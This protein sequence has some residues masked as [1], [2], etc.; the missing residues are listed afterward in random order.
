MPKKILVTGGAGYIG[1]HTCVELSQSGYELVIY[2]NLSNSSFE[3]VKRVEKITNKS[4]KF[5]QG[6]ILD[7]LLLKQTFLEHDFYGVMHFAGLKAVGESVQ[8]PLLYYK[9]NVT[10]TLNLLDV[11]KQYDVKNLV[12]SSSATVYGDPEKLPILENSKRSCTNPYG[13]TKLTIEYVLEDLAKS[14][15][16]QDNGWNIISLRYFNPIGAHESGLIGEDPN[17]IPNNLMPYISQVA[18]GKLERLSVFGNDY[19]TVD[20]TGVRDYIHVVDLAKGHV[21]AIEYISQQAQPVGFTPINLGTGC[22]TSVLQLVNAFVE[23]TG[24]SIPYVVTS[25]RDGDI[26]SCYASVDKAKKLLNWQANL[27]IGDMCRDTWQWQ[28]KNPLGYK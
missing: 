14:E 2:D 25:R 7:Q 26:A 16:N 13:Q 21:S 22:G 23:N 15:N 19:D 5:I 20:G 6:D 10:G 24:Q 11:M 3:A 17:D 8:H 18:V 4:I 27:T 9:N 12:F 1:S 28:N